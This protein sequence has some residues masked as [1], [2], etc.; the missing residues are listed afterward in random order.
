MPCWKPCLPNITHLGQV[1]ERLLEQS[2]FIAAEARVREALALEPDNP[3]LLYQLGRAILGRGQESEALEIFNVGLAQNE[4]EPIRK[5]ANALEAKNRLVE[6]KRKEAQAQ[7]AEADRLFD[8]GEIDS[9]DE[10]LAQVEKTE[11]FPVITYVKRANIAILLGH[12]DQATSFLDKAHQRE[13]KNPWVH[14]NRALVSE[15]RNDLPTA[16]QHVGEALSSSPENAN[17]KRAKARLEIAVKREESK[18]LRFDHQPGSDSDFGKGQ[19][20]LKVICWDLSH[21]PAGR[22][23]V[24]AEVAEAFA[25]PELA[26]PVFLRNGSSVWMPLADSKPGYDI[27]SW[28]AG[29]MSCFISGAIRYVLDNPSDRVWVSKAR[30]PSLF[31]GCL[32][33]LIHNSAMVVDL[34]DDELSFV[35]EDEALELGEFIEAEHD[36]DWTNP[37]APEWARVAEGMVEWA[38]AITCCNEVLQSRYGGEI[39]RHVRD[40]RRFAPDALNRTKLREEL[41]LSQQDKVMLFMGT[42]R[43]HKG[44]LEIAR[45]VANLND[46]NAMLLLVGSIPEPQL[47]DDLNSIPGLRMRHLAD[48]PLSDA[49]V[50][51]FVADLACAYQDG[52]HRIAQTQTPA[53]LSDAAVSGTLSV[54]TR[55]QTTAPFVKAGAAIVPN[56]GEPLVDLLRRGLQLAAD[57]SVSAKARD[58]FDRELSLTA[59]VPAAL[60]AFEA[61]QSRPSPLPSS[62]QVLLRLIQRRLPQPDTPELVRFWKTYADEPKPAVGVCNFERDLDVVFFW[63]QNDTGIYQRRQDSV[64]EALANLPNVRKILHIE[65]PI[66]VNRLNALA[67]PVSSNGE[68]RLVAH[69]TVSRFLKAADQTDV[70]YRSFITAGKETTLLGHKLYSQEMFSVQ[71]ARWMEELG[72]GDNTL[73]WLCPVVPEFEQVQKLIGFKDVVCDVI[74][75]QRRWPMQPA[76]RRN[77]DLAYNHAFQTSD[78]TFSNCEPVAQWLRSQGLVPVVVPNGISIPKDAAPSKRPS[79]LKTFDGPVVGYVGNMSD[80]IDWPLLNDLADAQPD[81][82]LVF[83]GKLPRKESSAFSAFRDR[84]NVVM[85][86]VVPAHQVSDWLSSMDVGI[87]PHLHTRLSEAMNPLKLYVYRAHGLRVVSLPVSNLE[88]FTD[89]IAI[90]HSVDDM[91]AA[92]SAALKDKSKNGPKPMAPDKVQKYVWTTRVQTMMDKIRTTLSEKGQYA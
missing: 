18:I 21:N 25:T 60:R 8:R 69:K 16:L 20:P 4:F 75:D 38:D 65:A 44:I 63:K 12:T 7:I 19:P 5:I 33:K 28:T 32:Y 47:R 64:H 66:S 68:D 17:F 91:R 81:W 37:A 53:K 45:A 6:Q 50:M 82:T 42:P 51:N 46:P 1:A 77:L 3:W 59:N 84:P 31:V 11:L 10:I 85:P 67:N 70:H 88:D 29:D 86:G 9:A 55:L 13:A 35:D 39:I 26:G 36:I 54:T 83:I 80:R 57:P 30:F 76:A 87:I 23:A 49:P 89:E 78:V 22:A 24:L 40:Q 43:R 72:I 92:I 34:D 62:F 73:A 58:F 52:S 48:H 15:I 90:A 27:T 41:G 79:L 74:D 2:K 71:V 56:P 61:A 14:Y